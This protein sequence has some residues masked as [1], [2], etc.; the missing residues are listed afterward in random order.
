M[1][2]RRAGLPASEFLD[3]LRSQRVSRLCII[4]DGVPLAL[5][6]GSCLLDGDLLGAARAGT[7]R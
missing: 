1:V 3:L 6:V 4:D 5:P 7:R 2:T